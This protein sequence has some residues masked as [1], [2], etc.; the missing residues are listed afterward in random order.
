MQSFLSPDNHFA[1]WTIL[2]GASA[3]GIVGERKKWFGNISGVLVTIFLTAI[4]ATLNVLPSATNSE[5]KVGV[6][7]FVFDYIIPIS[8]PLLL[9]NVNLKRIVKES[10]RLLLVFLLGSFGVVLGAVAAFYL[11]PIGEE[12][13][14][15]AG[16]FIGT[17]TGGS[18]NFMA[19]AAVLDFLHSPLF[20]A[21]MVVDNVFTNFYIMFLF[22]IPGF[23]FL[24]KFYPGYE[25]NAAEITAA[26]TPE[27]VAE[28][29]GFL[30][31]MAMSLFISGLVCAIGFWLSKVLQSSFGIKINLDLLVITA[32]ITLVANIFPNA[33]HRFEQV[34]FDMG[35]FLM[36]VFLAVIGASCDLVEMFSVAPE[37]LVFCTIILVVHFFV[38]LLGGKLLNV[39]LKEILVASA[40]NIGG[41][42]ISAPMAAT[43][44][45]KKAV[46]PAVLIG[47]LGYVIGTFLGVSVGLWLQ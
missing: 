8:I 36:F 39:S 33:L 24:L 12:A 17:Y 40:A 42:S 37:V 4:L 18:V 46:T 1:I 28:E 3:F 34:A 44:G 13:F 32:L 19:V 16:V 21:T 38:I 6:Y 31:K 22:L 29:V 25:E 10:G 5:I 11:V 35:M 45:M 20:A 26:P 15:L 2:V 30:E 14:K 7:H 27:T 43:L 41:A 47:I 23:A 9:F